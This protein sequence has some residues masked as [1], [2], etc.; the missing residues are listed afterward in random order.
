MTEAGWQ[1]SFEHDLAE[2][3]RVLLDNV[4]DAVSLLD[5]AGRP[6]STNA[7]MERLSAELPEL[8][9]GDLEK[10][11]RLA[12]RVLDPGRYLAALGTMVRDPDYADT[13]EFALERDERVFRRYVGPIVSDSVGYSG[14]VVVICEI[15][16][17]RRAARREADLL[18]NVSHELR[19]PLANIVGFSELLI[20]EGLGAEERDRYL[21]LLGGEARKLAGLVNDF[22]DLERIGR[23]SFELVRRPFDLVAVVRRESEV[24]AA[25]GDGHVLETRLPRRPVIVLGAEERAAQAL[26]NLLSN[27][28]KYSRPG[29][30]VRVSLTVRRRWARVAVA[31]DG[32]GILR[33]QQD[34]IFT[35]FF[36]ADDEQ[37][38]RIGGT[39]LG[40]ALT[41]ELVDAQGGRIGFDS[42]KGRGSTFWFELPLVENGLRKAAYDDSPGCG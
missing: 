15:S 14:R 5:P 1:R 18:A 30:G 25:G 24:F 11:A 34:K 19:T 41:R 39:G 38:R 27:A 3:N 42:R 7:A 33:S 40:L 2:L 12:D 28:F 8:A 36:R 23:G 16:E 17:E 37:V 26:T 31:D 29:G 6:I 20:G 9:R 32:I 4:R 13:D 10:S 21:R 22:L 35:K